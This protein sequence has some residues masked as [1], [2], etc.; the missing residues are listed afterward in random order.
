MKLAQSPYHS[1]DVI[2]SA[3]K[4]H[5]LADFDLIVCDEAHRTTGATFEGEEE[6][7]F[8][9]EDRRATKGVFVTTSSYSADATAFAKRATMRIVLI[10]GV[11]LARLMARHNVGVREDRR[12]IIKKLDDEYFDE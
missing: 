7:T 6:S 11:E 2:G 12:V 9:L 3:Q 4:K 8:S 10:D 1:I 5:K